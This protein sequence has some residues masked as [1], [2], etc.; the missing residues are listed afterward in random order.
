MYPEEQASPFPD[1]RGFKVTS[2]LAGLLKKMGEKCKQYQF[3][4]H[5]CN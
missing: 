1:S 5:P 3:F 2:I 4:L